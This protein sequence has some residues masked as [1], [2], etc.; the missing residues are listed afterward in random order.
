MDGTDKETKS[1]PALQE[2]RLAD[3]ETK[4]VRQAKLNRRLRKI[5]RRIIEQLRAA[6]DEA[7]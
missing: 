7:I 2:L 4:K 5:R 6:I 3:E 1:L